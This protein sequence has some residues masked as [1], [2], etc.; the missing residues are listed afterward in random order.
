M[1]ATVE[2]IV[3]ARLMM[4]SKQKSKPSVVLKNISPVLRRIS[5]HAVKIAADSRLGA[6]SSDGESELSLEI[7][8]VGTCLMHDIWKMFLLNLLRYGA[9]HY[10]F[11]INMTS[12]KPVPIKKSTSK[13]IRATKGIYM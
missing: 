5:H 2:A 12:F 3:S 1:M 6:A 8:D 11:P 7:M 10:C 9:S 13:A 4:R